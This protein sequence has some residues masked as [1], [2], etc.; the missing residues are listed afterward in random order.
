MPVFCQ[1]ILKPNKQV[2]LHA[3][4]YIKPHT[5]DIPATFRIHLQSDPLFWVK[6]GKSQRVFWFY[7]TSMRKLTS[8]ER[9]CCFR[10]LTLSLL[11]WFSASSID[12]SPFF[13]LFIMLS[14]ISLLSWEHQT[15]RVKH[16]NHVSQNQKKCFQILFPFVKEAHVDF[17]KMGNNLGAYA[18][19]LEYKLTLHHAVTGT[20]NLPLCH[21]CESIKQPVWGST[22]IKEEKFI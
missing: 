16:F 14:C 4:I 11:A 12:S 20:H 13:T 21:S 19:F 18:K 3:K 6:P 15:F 1:P 5:E 10:R 8:V 17:Q 9:L 22:D 7:S 2:K